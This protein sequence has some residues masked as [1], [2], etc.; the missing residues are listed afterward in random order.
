MLITFG[1]EQVTWQQQAEQRGYKYLLINDYE[2]GCKA[3]NEYLVQV[4]GNQVKIV[5]FFIY[6]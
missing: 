4:N 6:L 5:F 1:K 2:Q 3:I